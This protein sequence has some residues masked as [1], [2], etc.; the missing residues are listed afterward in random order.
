MPA[1]IAQSPFGNMPD[2]TAVDIFTLTNAGGLLCKVISYGAAVTELHVPDRD[3]RL[4]DVVLGFDNLPQY[5]NESPCFG[6]VCGRV[7]NRI[8]YGRFTLDGQTYALGINDPPHSLHGGF[9]GYDKVVWKARGAEGPEGP[10]VV[11][12]HLSA[13]GDG[14]YPGALRLRMTYTLTNA[15]ELRFDYEATTD[16]ATPVNL[17]NHSYFNLAGTKDIFAH[18]L[19]LD[20][21]RYTPC[22]S[23]LIPT[24]AVADV[25][26]GPLDFRQEKPIGRD[27]AQLPGGIG[28]YDHNFLIDGA[29]RG[30][31]HAATV[32]E[33]STGRAIDVSTDQPAIQVY[34]SNSLLR[35]PVG[36]QGVVYHRYAGLCLE[37]QHYP[38]SVNHPA[39][40]TTILQPGE[41][42]R[43]T[44]LYAFSAH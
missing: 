19:R 33:A 39:F 36:K 18:T 4:A 28:G 37:T 6:S 42:F 9:K 22:G 12:E 29:G 40:P 32:R 3:G 13:D 27:F 15:N 34:T 31:V 25:A 16:R 14:G 2:G 30:L 10:A 8:A 41:T 17:T 7:A 20:A 44:T 43:S 38:D 11:F 35:K 26:G 1:R 24:G 21:S 5:V 23:D